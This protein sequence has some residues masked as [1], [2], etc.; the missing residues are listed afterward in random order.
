MNFVQNS[1]QEFGGFTLVISDAHEGLRK[2][3]EQ[4]LEA[5]WQRCRVHFVRNALAHVPKAQHSMV[6][7]AIRTVFVQEDQASARAQWR[8]VSDSLR[9]RFPK[10]AALMDEAEMDVLAHMAFPR[11]HWRQI[12][13]TNPLERL[14]KEIKRRTDV[15]GI[16]PNEDAI[17][18]LVGALL[19]EQTDEWH[20]TRRYMNLETLAQ[21]TGDEGTTVP[22]GTLSAASA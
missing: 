16:F 12:A 5:S 14:N 8:H 6:A 11:E 20:V 13:S 22:A 17:V 1:V 21:V 7:A 4:V 10:V 19:A 3:A 18:R 15:V 2:A 9:G